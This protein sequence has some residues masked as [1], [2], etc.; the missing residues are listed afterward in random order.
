MIVC[1]CNVLSDADILSC[2][3]ES[4][5]KRLTPA[6][7]HRALGSR[8]LCGCCAKAIRSITDSARCACGAEACSRSPQL[9][10]AVF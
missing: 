7:V 1:S 4:E 2:V 10:P 8:P 5:G 6:Q 3:I 9:S